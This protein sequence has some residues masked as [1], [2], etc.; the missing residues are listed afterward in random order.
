MNS[1]P[2]CPGSGILSV[3]SSGELAL[4]GGEEGAVKVY[5]LAQKKIARTLKTDG[6]VTDAVWAGDKAIIA[7]STGTVKV[8][9]KATE[10][11]KIKTHAGAATALAVHPSGD[12]AASVGA[13]K[14]YVL[15]DLTTNSMVAQVFSDACKTPP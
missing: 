9:E 14:S 6:P 13:D 8:F 4:V 10:L 2:L 1:K 11:A 12:I 7:S 15:Y 3:N 5:S